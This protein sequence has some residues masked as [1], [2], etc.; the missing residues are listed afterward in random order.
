MNLFLYSQGPKIDLY[1]TKNVKLEWS[2][3]W[4]EPKSNLKGTFIGPTTDQKQMK[5]VPKIKDLDNC[6]KMKKNAK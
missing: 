6:I 4:S 1:Y 2:M 5:N 3:T